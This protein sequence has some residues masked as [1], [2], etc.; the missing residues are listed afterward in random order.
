MMS[1]E[2]DLIEWNAEFNLSE[3]NFLGTVNESD[4]HDANTRA[5]VNY[6]F[7]HRV[8]EDKKRWKIK[9]E[10]IWTCAYFFPNNS[11]LRPKILGEINLPRL[12]KHEQ[13]HFDLAEKCSRRFEKKLK[14][15]FRNKTFSF[16]KNLVSDPE[17]EV[18]KLIQIEFEILN[19]ELVQGHIDYDKITNHGLITTEQE[20]F[21]A[22]FEQLR[23][24]K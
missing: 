8:N 20:K 16:N 6:F 21:D 22:R 23:D 13:G 11:W 10:E 19:E 24:R 9:V 5:G 14:N 15:K 7:K 3:N 1:D 12:I 2:S 17:V 18:K 4:P